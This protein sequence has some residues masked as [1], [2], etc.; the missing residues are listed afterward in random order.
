MTLPVAV[1]SDT[2]PLSYLHRLGRLE[3]LQQL[4]RRLLVP[5][6]VVAELNVGLRLGRDLPDVT[7]L[8]WIELRSPP[9]HALQGIDGLGAGETEGIA[10]SRSLPGS[11]VLL[12]DGYA[13]TVAASLGLHITGTAGV[14]VVAKERG[15]L[16]LVRPELERLQTFGFRLATPVWRAVLE[17]AGEAG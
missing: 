3:L 9:A 8:D 14:L 13:R 7:T 2:G 1:I 6:A 4:Y 11:L 10:L 15:L 12:D 17:R 16:D 5:P